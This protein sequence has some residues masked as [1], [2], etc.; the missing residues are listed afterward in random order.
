MT[1]AEVLALITLLDT[2]F[3]LGGRL[4][5]AAVKEKPILV[6]DPLP[7]PVDLDTARSEA[8]DRLRRDGD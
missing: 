3:Q 6:L 1:P 5:D 7:D 4:V 2:V 8:L